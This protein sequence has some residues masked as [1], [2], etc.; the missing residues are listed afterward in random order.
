MP[1]SVRNRTHWA[2]KR[3]KK[4]EKTYIFFGAK[5]GKNV[6]KLVR[7][8]EKGSNIFCYRQQKS[9]AVLNT[10]CPSF[11]AREEF[12]KWNSGR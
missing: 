2:K 4:F 11:D 12:E 5:I 10:A 9:E 3:E 8:N 6:S 7:K 1:K